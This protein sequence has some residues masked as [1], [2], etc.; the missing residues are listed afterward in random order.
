[1]SEDAASTKLDLEKLRIAGASRPVRKPPNWRITLAVAALL[2]LAGGTY[3][4]HLL[5]G[6][7][8]PV[9]QTAYVETRGAGQPGTLLT[10]S[11]YIVTSHKY[12]TI[13]TKIL[14]QIVAEPVQEGQHVRAGDLLARI[15]DRDY[16]AQLRQAEANQAIAAANLKLSQSQAERDRN[17]HAAGLMSEDDYETATSA[18][19]VADATLKSDAAAVDYARFMVSQCVIRSPIDGIVLQKYRELGDTINYGGEVQAG[20]G[21][22][23]IAQ[24]A[25]T[26]DMRAQVDVNESDIGKLAMGSPAS[27]VLD[28]YP[29]K[30]FD[31][32]LVKIYPAADRQ[33][34]TVRVEVHLTRPDLAFVKPEMGAKVSFL[35]AARSAVAAP[36]LSIPKSALLTAEGKSTVWVLRDGAV[37][38][39][40]VTPGAAAELSVEIS[41][42]LTSGEVVVLAP[43]ATLTEGQ[44]VK[45]AA[46]G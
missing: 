31:A 20:G 29:D 5:A 21:A 2:L 27:V 10:G 37:H 40:T 36:T 44:K 45:V 11:G 41:S 42:G 38:R 43:S 7:A 1:M 16:Q 34:G 28:A 46:G 19:A 9:V 22:T 3:G 14:G 17:L 30:S 6:R 4:A 33:K 18:A 32:A 12:I 23:D 26:A 39:V 25:D 8:M 24:L 35:S 13:G 15:D